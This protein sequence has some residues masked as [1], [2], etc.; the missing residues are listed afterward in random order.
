MD[1]LEEHRFWDEYIQKTKSYNIPTKSVR[2][3]VKRVEDFL[4]AYPGVSF[5]N[6]T[7]EN[8]ENYLKRVSR[9]GRLRDWQFKQL[10][11]SLKILF[12]DMAQAQWSTQFSWDFWLESATDLPDSHPTVARERAILPSEASNNADKPADLANSEN[13]AKNTALVNKVRT[14]FPRHFERLIVSIRTKQYSIRTEQAYVNWLARYIAFHDMQDPANLDGQSTKE[15]LEYLVVKR[16]VSASTQSQALCAVVFFYK[17]VLE[18]ELGD[19]GNFTHSKKPRRLPVVLTQAEMANLLSKIEHPTYRLMANLLYGCGMRLL[20]CIR[21]RIFDV[22][23]N[24]QQIIIRNAKGD[25]DRVVPLP[26]RLVNA[27]NEQI[28]FVRTQHQ[29]DLTA[30]YGDVYLPYALA[31]K[32]PNASKEI[33]W[34]YLFPSSK[35]S[36]DPRSKTTRRHHIYETVLQKQIKKATQEAGLCKRVSSH[37]LRHSFATHLLEIGYDIRTVQELLGHADVSTTMIYTHVLN[38]PGVSVLS[39]L[40]QLD[41]GD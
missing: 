20:E 13:D 4:Q 25:K 24:Y 35:L 30:G 11:N 7:P 23:F 34:Q 26:K 16:H 27:L 39:P 41:I 28:A 36:I 32:Y 5:P 2:W 19:L 3:Y 8:V 17:Q 40:D 12:T 6:H 37:S 31:R 1:N 15:F 21:L 10:V 14:L 33:G 38:K 18:T 22:D 29:E 9:N